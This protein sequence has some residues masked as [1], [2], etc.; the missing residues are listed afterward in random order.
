MTFWISAVLACLATVVFFLIKGNLKMQKELTEANKELGRMRNQL[1]ILNAKY[2]AIVQDNA[3]MR[4]FRTGH[5]PD[6]D[7]TR[8]DDLK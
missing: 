6:Q 4:G 2:I 7:K 3:W 5:N 1:D 8:E